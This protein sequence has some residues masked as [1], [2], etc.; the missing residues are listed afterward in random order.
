MQR[1][2]SAAASDA[3]RHPKVDDEVSQ[4]KSNEEDFPEEE[5]TKSPKKQRAASPPAASRDAPDEAGA[6]S[7]SKEEAPQ[8]VAALAALLPS[9]TQAPG[10]TKENAPT[11][12]QDLSDVMAAAIDPM[13]AKVVL[14]A[15]WTWRYNVP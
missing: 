14:A 9:P 15:E 12:G 10:L 6:A 11:A 4:N 2:R 5:Q 13:M 3:E 7:K 1:D 8:S